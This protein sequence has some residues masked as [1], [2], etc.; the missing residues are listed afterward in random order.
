MIRRFNYTGRKKIER[1]RV[2]IALNNKGEG[3]AAFDADLHL[4]DLPVLREGRVFLEAYYRSSF[5]RFDFGTIANPTRP[6]NRRLSDIDGGEVVFFRVRVVDPTGEH[7]QILA[8]VDGITPRQP[9]LVTEN[10]K[11]LLHVN[12]KDLGDEV[13]RLDLENT[14]PVLEVNDQIENIRD[15][16]LTD[17]TFQSLVYPAAVREI[18]QRILIIDEYDPTE[19]TG[20]WASLWLK[21]V[22]G[23]HSADPPSLDPESDVN[24]QERLDWI[25]DAVQ[26][27]C[28]VVSAKE[29]F[30]HCRLEGR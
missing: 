29:N 17:R 26:S 30:V 20:E 24:R 6:A 3:G 4:D 14:M 7:G 13:W 9:G 18:L 10:R 27:F 16:I 22:R 25:E 19:D 1:T 12:F 21:F 5:M 28:Q 11:C 2:A 23:F 8:E 15:I